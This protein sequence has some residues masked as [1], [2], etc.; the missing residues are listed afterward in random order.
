MLFFAQVVRNRRIYAPGD[1]DEQYEGDA[2]TADVPKFSKP[3]AIVRFPCSTMRP[4]RQT[5][6]HAEK[7]DR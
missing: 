5:D 1:H 3:S 6:C 2:A 7:R 4:H